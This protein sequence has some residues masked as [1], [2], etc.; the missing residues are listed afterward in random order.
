MPLGAGDIVYFSPFVASPGSEYGILA[1][2]EHIRPLTDTEIASQEVAIRAAMRPHD[3]IH[4]PQ[5]SRYD[6]REFIY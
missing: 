3:P 6:I 4:P 1:E 2:A 5:F